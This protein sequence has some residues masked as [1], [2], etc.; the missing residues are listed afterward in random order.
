MRAHSSPLRRLKPVS[1]ARLSSAGTPY[2]KEGAIFSPL[3]PVNKLSGP[4]W[5][6][7]VESPERV[8]HFF[9]RVVG[10]LLFSGFRSGSYFLCAC[11]RLFGRELR[12]IRFPSR[13]AEK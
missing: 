5:G 10:T 2:P 6:G 7:S 13:K 3:C 1:L 12:P 11:L 4:Q 9:F 8:H